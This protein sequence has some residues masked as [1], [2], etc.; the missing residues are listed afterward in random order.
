MI[1][2][3]C[4]KPGSGKSEVREILERSFGFE[5]V[6][7]KRIL[8]K[9]SADITGLAVSDFSNPKIKNS[10]FKGHQLRKITGEL[11]NTVENLFGD[12]HLVNKAVSELDLAR[13]NYVVDSL[14]KT[15]TK[16]FPGIVVEVVSERGYD[17]GNDFDLYDRSRINYTLPNHTTFEQLER[18][19]VKMLDALGCRS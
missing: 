9:M 5:T 16:D 8:Y 12:S 4:G 11:G 1:I 14:R 3:L 10:I 18:N 19:I 6:C 2:G 13:A 15:Q 17:T 7:S